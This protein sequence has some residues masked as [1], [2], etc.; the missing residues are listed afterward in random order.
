M[1]IQGVRA[2]FGLCQSQ[3]IEME[4]AGKIQSISLRKPGKLRGKRLYHADSIRKH[5][6]SLLPKPKADDK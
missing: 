6:N 3:V 5:L 4:A 2:H 1:D